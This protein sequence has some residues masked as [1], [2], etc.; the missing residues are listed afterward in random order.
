[1]YI[2]LLN[3]LIL[4]NL[5]SKFLDDTFRKAKA[6]PQHPSFLQLELE[7]FRLF[8]RLLQFLEM[9]QCRSLRIL[10]RSLFLGDTFYNTKHFLTLLVDNKKVQH[11]ITELEFT[12][13][14]NKKNLPVAYVTQDRRVIIQSIN[15]QRSS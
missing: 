4:Q 9:L 7:C 2:I 1:V 10:N 8:R 13:L 6:T 15:I 12:S 11:E 5:A 3:V 14:Q